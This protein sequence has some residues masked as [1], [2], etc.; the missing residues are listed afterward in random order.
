MGRIKP[1]VEIKYICNVID[2]NIVAH[3]VLNDRGLLSENI[4]AQ[5][6][7]LTEDIAI[8]INNKEN[9]LDLDCHYD[10]VKPSMDYIMGIKKYKYIQKFHHFLQSTVSHYTPSENDAERLMLYYFG[11]L[12]MLKETLEGECS[13]KVLHKL[14]DFPIYEDN[15]TK[16]HYQKICKKIEEVQDKTNKSLK[17]GRFYVNKCR[18]I[19][20]FGKLY[21]EL[22]LSKATNYV[23]K[24]E[25]ILMYSKYYIPDNYSIKLSYIEKEVELFSYKSKVK[26]IDNYVISIRPCEIKNIGKIFGMTCN[27]TDEYM[28]YTNLM[29]ILKENELNLLE[30]LTSDDKKYE[31]YLKEIRLNAKNNNVSNILELLHKRLGANLPGNN[32]LKY[33]LV[34]ME[35]NIIKDQLDYTSN[36]KFGNLYLKNQ[37]IPFDS[38]PYAMALYKHNTSWIH[39]VN[40]I[41]S[42]GREHEMLGKYIKD[43]SENNN[44]LYTDVAEVEKF[45]NVDKLVKQYNLDLLNYGIDKIGR[46]SIKIEHGLLYINSYE[47]NSI[48]IIKE[49]KKYMI[50]PSD[51]MIESIKNNILNYPISDLTEDKI[52]IFDVIFREN[53]IAFIHGP[54]GTGKTKML[55]VVATVF[56]DYSKIFLSNTNT[57]VEN[58]RRRIINYDNENSIFET[59]THYNKNDD[60]IY[61]ILIIDECSTISDDEM[62]K[63]LNKQKYKLIILS[64]DIYQIE[65]IKYGNWTFLT[66]NLFKDEFVYELIETN[67]TEDHDL[68]ELWKLVRDDDDHAINKISNKE[69]SSPIDENIF[70][71]ISDDEIILCLNYDGLYGINNINRILQEKNLNK[72]YNVG[73]D[74]FKV[75]DPIVFNDCPRFKNLYN[76]LKGKIKNIEID[77]E[78]DRVWFTILVDEVLLDTPINY[79][80]IEI[81]D[82][83]TLIKFFVNNFKD[84]NDDESE[85]DHIIPFNLAY[86]VSIH[87]A[88]GLE[89]ESVKIIITSNV[90]DKIT[91]NILY[92]AITRAKKYLQ[93]FWSPE[94]QQRIFEQI[95]KRKN[96][97]DISILKRKLNI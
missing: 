58:L 40:S 89:Y 37:S 62:Q 30:L 22:T 68:L 63:I 34:K 38:M 15:M 1:E 90:E 70:K 13:L 39:L 85:Y 16:E 56:K 23:N 3:K 91:K 78:N 59:T 82:N 65:S 29:R 77:N 83:K 54:A 74:L 73:V 88:Q 2:K 20:A 95:K 46:N 19:Y 60:N 28:E 9:G 71:R 94:S 80:V 86:A 76:N 52:K 81:T 61:D 69:Y 66:Y 4:L 57:A 53:S 25:H 64:G 55:E 12:C 44:I 33:L 92:T 79:E 11:Y 45:G 31:G 97:R 24:F 32:I 5:L 10:N 35:N 42:S 50:K 49:I 84:T 96:S 21:Y 27:I 67:R 87:K 17:R 47:T 93:I 18:P 7:N 75:D 43:N 8:L 6:R 26:V 72:E 14:E 51:D 48:N 41:D 36:E